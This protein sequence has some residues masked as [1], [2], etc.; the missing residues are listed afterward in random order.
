[1]QNENLVD[2]KL[3]KI[4]RHLEYL[5]EELIQMEN[6]ILLLENN[7]DKIICDIAKGEINC[8]KGILSIIIYLMKKIGI[9]IKVFS[10]KNENDI[11]ET[12]QISKK[13][14][15][16]IQSEQNNLKTK[17]FNSN[18]EKPKINQKIK[19]EQKKV[20]NFPDYFP[21][22]KIS[23]FSKKKIASQFVDNIKKNFNKENKNKV[24]H[25]SSKKKSDLSTKKDELEKKIEIENPQ[26]KKIEK[27]K[28]RG[29]YRKYSIAQRKEA[30][31]LAEKLDDINTTALI[32]DVPIKNLKR[33]LKNGYE[34]K[35][36]G[37]KTQ[38]PLMEIKLTAWIK[39]F[40]KFNK[41]MPEHKLIKK[42]AL[43][44][45]NFKITF[46]ASKG[47]YEKFILRHF[48]GFAKKKNDKKNKVFQDKAEQNLDS[49]VNLKNKK[50]LKVIKSLNI[51]SGNEDKKSDCIFQDDSFDNEIKLSCFENNSILEPM[52]PKNKKKIFN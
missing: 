25:Q 46:K 26:K 47:W 15:Y 48:A 49:K 37:R 13:C 50:N 19:S 34:R 39:D 7:F 41:K 30:I 2:E 1:M 51:L 5:N 44:L 52:T 33:W 40:F 29:S 24:S 14:D 35:K 17:I 11:N 43:K 12:Q 45:S 28:K 8:F 9:N 27:R 32:L 36:G 23:D 6:E 4:M 31:A 18:F 20:K 22:N 38:D 16:S 3:K 10:K 21:S 42:M